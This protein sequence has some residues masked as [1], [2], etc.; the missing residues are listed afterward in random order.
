M[1]SLKSNII[2]LKTELFEKL[3]YTYG[4]MQHF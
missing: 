4:S 3:L 2:F 1:L